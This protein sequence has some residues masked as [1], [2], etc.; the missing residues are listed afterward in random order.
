MRLLCYYYVIHILCLS[1]AY[2]FEVVTDG[3]V[4]IILYATAISAKSAQTNPKNLDTNF[5]LFAVCAHVFQTKT[6]PE[7]PIDQ[8]S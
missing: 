2:P 5:A 6:T 3:N 4:K 7:L 1:Y 8:P